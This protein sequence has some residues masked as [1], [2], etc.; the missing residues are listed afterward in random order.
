MVAKLGNRRQVRMDAK[1]EEGFCISPP[2]ISVLLQQSYS[3][4]HSTAF[5]NEYSWLVV[6]THTSASSSLIVRLT[7]L[8]TVGDR[9]FPV[10]AAPNPILVSGTSCHVCTVPASFLQSSEDFIFSAVPFLTFCNAC[11][12]TCILCGH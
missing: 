12:E 6:F 2:Y 5:A 4:A 1:T 11:E 3:T 9:A 8:S 10:A 7:R